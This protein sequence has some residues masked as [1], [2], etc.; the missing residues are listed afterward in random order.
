MSGNAICGAAVA[1]LLE[2]V[3]AVVVGV[4]YV[5]RLGILHR[6]GIG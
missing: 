2:L 1:L 4:F 5:H 6:L 3:C